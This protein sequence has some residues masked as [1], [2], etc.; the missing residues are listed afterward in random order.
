MFYQEVHI[1]L[2]TMINK[3]DMIDKAHLDTKFSRFIYFCN[4]EEADSRM[5]ADAVLMLLKLMIKMFY[6][7]YKDIS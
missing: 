1:F 7:L 5:I 2:M 4:H 3:E 6:Y